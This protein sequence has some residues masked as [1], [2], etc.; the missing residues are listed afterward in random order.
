MHSERTAS[1]LTWKALQ[2]LD[3]TTTTRAFCGRS[4]RPLHSRAMYTGSTLQFSSLG[5]MQAPE[6]A[7]VAPR[8]QPAPARPAAMTP[9]VEI[10]LD[11][12]FRDPVRLTIAAQPDEHFAAY[13]NGRT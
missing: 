3:K 11:P 2:R 9:F 5:R 4:A 10:P 6:P 1:S 8:V 7:P 12:N 13:F